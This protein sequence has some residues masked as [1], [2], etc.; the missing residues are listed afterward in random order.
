MILAGQA[1]DYLFLRQQTPFGLEAVP[2]LVFFLEGTL[3]CLLIEALR[4]ARRRAEASKAEAE[5]EHEIL[6]RSEEHFVTE[7][8]EAKEALERS[9][10]SHAASALENA[11]LYTELSERENQLRDLVG[12]LIMAQ[13]VETTLFRVAQES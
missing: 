6:R 12:R 3:L 13:E 5:R 9:L 1:T 7:Q 2:L 11:R 10:T 8:K 4:V